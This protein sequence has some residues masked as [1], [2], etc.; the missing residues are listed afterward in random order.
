MMNWRDLEYALEPLN[1]L[2]LSH[3]LL[4]THSTLTKRFSDLEEID[5]NIKNYTLE[6]Q[7][8]KGEVL[9][10]FMHSQGLTDH[11]YG[12]IGHALRT[13]GY[14]PLLISCRGSLS[15]C[16]RKQDHPDTDGTCV[17]CRYKS[18]TILDSYGFRHIY[19]NNYTD[20]VGSISLPEN[21]NDLWSMSYQGVNISNFA[22]ATTRRHLRK[23]HIDLSDENDRNTFERF[24][25]SAIY[26]VNFTHEIINKR[27][28]IAVIGNHPPYI[29]SGV[30]LE[31]AANK[32]VPAISYG[33]G[34]LREDAIIFGNMK[35]RKG[36]ELFSDEQ[37]LNEQLADPL[38]PEQR[39][40]IQFYMKGRR[41]GS[42]IRDMN[43]YIKSAE[44]RL[45]F[46]TSSQIVC[47]FTNLIWDGSLSD[48]A[49]TFDTPFKWVKDTIQFMHGL[50]DV[51]LIL[52]PHPAEAHRETKVRM[53]E[54]ARSEIDIPDNVLILEA[55][56]DINP[57]EL[58]QQIDAGIVFNS[59]VGMEAVYEGV[60]VITVGDTHY[61]NM[62]FTHDPQS[63]QEYFKIIKQIS[64]LTLS[65][66]QKR[67][68]ERYAYFLLVERHISIEELD[69]ITEIHK[70][71]H[72]IIAESEI[73]DTIIN[74]IL[75]N[76]RSPR[77]SRR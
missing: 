41:D 35:N 12:F 10:P 48:S 1:K 62:G 51:Q 25:V 74:Q 26:L 32:C 9:L 31:A 39:E 43:H 64:D 17:N 68:A 8:I 61:R 15:L 58:M 20:D 23:Y 13:R 57:Y 65:E 19:L 34:Y 37:T 27:D 47:M 46:E 56:T 3:S 76:E 38:S 67:L 60:P 44:K 66:E 6:E 5:D 14:R 18:D 28:V 55:D 29:Y 75:S 36:F 72:E 70:L 42:T 22:I 16:L 40:L 4:R 21:P 24:L 63:P 7:D 30:I 54:W 33:G 69:S 50:D 11:L 77:I 45:D 59:T 53:A 49:I 71:D 52:K 73:L 2:G